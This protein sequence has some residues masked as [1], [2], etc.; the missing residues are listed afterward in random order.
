MICCPLCKTLNED[1]SNYCRNCGKKIQLL[2]NP[3]QIFK[4][5]ERFVLIFFL[6]VLGVS[7]TTFIFSVTTNIYNAKISLFLTI[8]EVIQYSAFIF[9]AQSF[10]NKIL[11]TTGIV[12]S[13]LLICYTIYFTLYQFYF[14]PYIYLFYDSNVTLGF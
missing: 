9:L 11:K 13:I 10:K 4:N 2:S 7:L 6:I 1:R 8:L 5:K 14:L 12:V 3:N